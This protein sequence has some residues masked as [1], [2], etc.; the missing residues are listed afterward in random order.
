VLLTSN[1]AEEAQAFSKNHKLLPEIF[2]VDGVP[3]KT[4]VRSNPGLLLMKKGVV[5]NKWHYHNLPTYDN[6]VK[7][8]LQQ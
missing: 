1:S 2:Y 4:M 6:L 5:I 3:L 7:K 8:Y